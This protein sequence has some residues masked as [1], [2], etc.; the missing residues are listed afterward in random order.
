L[1]LI[2]PDFGERGIGIWDGSSFLYTTS[3]SKSRWAGW[4]DTLSAL[5]RYGP[6][7]PYRTNKVVGAMLAKFANLY[8]SDWLAAR[9]VMRSV[10]EF[11]DAADLG[12]AMT[13][14]SGETWARE[15]IGAGARWVNELMEG[16]TRC[17]VS[18]RTYVRVTWC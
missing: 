10:E 13:A 4:W 12:R 6:L 18:L 17:N 11:A 8:R 2:D 9:G 5:R 15:D 7:S 3:T 16:S 14:R 1:T